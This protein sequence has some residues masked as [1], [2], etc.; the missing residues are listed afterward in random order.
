MLQSIPVFLDLPN[1]IF[2]HH[3]SNILDLH[4]TCR[5]FS[6]NGSRLPYAQKMLFITDKP[7]CL[8]HSKMYNPLLI[9]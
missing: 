5:L 9:Q 7:H 6:L 3:T 8:S 2:Q 4:M 1:G